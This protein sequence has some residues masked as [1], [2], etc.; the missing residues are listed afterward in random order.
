MKKIITLFITLLAVIPH[1]NAQHSIARQ[2]NEQVL[3]AIRMDFARPTVHARNLFHTAAAMYDAWAVYE[4]GA[5]TYFLDKTVHGYNT[6]LLKFEMPTD[7]QAAQREAISYA[8]FRLMKHR[9]Q[10]S[11]QAEILFQ[12]LDIFMT[13][14]GY[15]PDNYSLDYGCSPAGMGNYIAAH[16]I[17][18]GLT[19]GSNEANSYENE[20]YKPVNPPLLVE[21]SGNP[22]MQDFN[23]WQ[24]LQFDVFIGQ[25]G[26]ASSDSVPDFLSPE[27]GQV[28][29]FSLQEADATIYQ[30]DGF[31]YK[32]YHDPSAPPY[33]DWLNGT[34]MTKEYNWGHSLVAIWSSHLDPADTTMWDISPASIGNLSIDSFP[35]DIP[36]LRNFYNTLEGG[37][38]STGHDLNPTT[39]LPYSPQIV[40]RADYARILAEFW[41][42]GPDSETPPGH[43]FTILNYVND[44]PE[45]EKRFKGQG[46]ILDDL[47]WDVKA[48]FILGGAMHDVAISAWGIKGWYDYVRPVSVIRAQ[49]VNGQSSD[50]TLDSYSPS[51]FELVPD[52][53]EIIEA[54]DPLAGANGENIGN[55]KIKAWKGPDFIVNPF[56]DIAGVDWIPAGNWYPYQ[57]PTFVTPPFAGYVSGHSTYSRAAAEVLT[58]LTGDPFFPG[59]VGE[60]FCAKDDFLVF[61]KGPSIDVT[62]QWATYRDA[63]DQCSL[64]RIWGGIH[65]PCDDIPGRLIGERIG[66][67]AFAFAEPYFTAPP[68]TLIQAN[69]LIIFPNPAQCMVNI[70]YDFEGEMP[71]QVFRNDGKL[72]RTTTVS[73][74][75]DQA[76]LNLGDLDGGV[77]ILVGFSGNER[78]FTEKV[79]VF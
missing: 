24:P 16:I 77:Y 75:N 38:Y 44:Q 56:F 53:I 70:E 34:G 21:E 27:W 59:G 46:E 7:K 29:P 37:D 49:E 42:D 55:L 13:S 17:N 57:R 3:E 10:H 30:R 15:H 20:F 6:P 41:A 51:G 65:P 58:A 43:W 36:S 39:G 47:E 18:Y 66:K 14:L 1:S 68:E 12:R 32:V 73:F 31:D 79:V 25:S 22:S 60:F 50:P 35:K 45:L 72:I 33:I 62:L 63:S 54:G 2:W 48:Y 11:P 9:F 4:D 71:I 28:K 8:V 74:E 69:D 5:D 52:Y 76:Y 67:D 78:L 40:K 61:E 26:I 19:D 23:R 64:S